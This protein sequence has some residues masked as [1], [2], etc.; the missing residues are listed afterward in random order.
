MISEVRGNTTEYTPHS[1]GS[2]LVPNG[3]EGNMF[4]GESREIRTSPRSVFRGDGFEHLNAK[5]HSSQFGSKMPELYTSPRGAEKP[6]TAARAFKFAGVAAA[7]VAIS[8]AI[9]TAIGAISYYLS[10]KKRKLFEVTAGIAAFFIAVPH[11]GSVF[12]LKS[13]LAKVYFNTEDL[14]KDLPTRNLHQAQREFKARY[15]DLTAYLRAAVKHGTND[16]VESAYHVG[17]PKLF[18][19]LFNEKALVPDR[20]V[21]L[22]TD[23]RVLHSIVGGYRHYDEPSFKRLAQSFKLGASS[24]AGSAGTPAEQ[25]KGAGRLIPYNSLAALAGAGILVSYVED[26]GKAGKLGGIP[27][28]PPSDA[29]DGS[30]DSSSP[31][32]ASGVGAPMTGGYA[33][34][35]NTPVTTTAVTG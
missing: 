11:L 4:K 20:C 29:S 10:G 25:A 31:V 17:V 5:T 26:Q 19:L 12:N 34:Y 30:P 32:Q 27:A 28:A 13:R 6:F 14:T 35:F 7:T 2:H 9:G 23:A 33:R 3:S 22:P 1:L 15:P 21:A 8:V 18:D 24:W 16:E